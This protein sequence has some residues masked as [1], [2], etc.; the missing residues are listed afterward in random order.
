[1]EVAASAVVGSAYQLARREGD[2]KMTKATR[3]TGAC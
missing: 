1:M 3:G 2:T